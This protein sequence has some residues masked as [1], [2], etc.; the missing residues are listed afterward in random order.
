MTYRHGAAVAVVCLA[1]AAVMLPGCAAKKAPAG[2]PAMAYKLAEGKPVAYRNVQTATQTMEVMGQSMNIETR[3]TMIFTV[4][5]GEMK[6]AGQHLT[7]TI[8][9]IDAG[10]TMPQGDFTADTAPVLGKTFEMTLSATGKE[11]DITG[12][13]VIQYGVGPAGERS[14]KPDFQA[15]FPD[16]SASPVKIGDT[17]TNTDTV[18]VDEAGMKL[19]IASV[20]VSTFE[21]VE[22]LNGIECAR[23]RAAV[24]GTVKGEGEQQGAPVVIDSQTEGTDLWLFA[25]KLGTLAKYTS[26]LSMN[27][28]VTVGGAQGMAI[29]MKQQIRT[30]TVLIK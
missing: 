18:D 28:T 21:G 1:V 29:P 12:A 3:K 10:M 7:V 16:L 30:E 8:D 25:L 5:P 22:P 6:T 17:W 19:R 24:T 4:T 13:D 2:A 23:I 26:D 14:I 9:S 27:G 20:Y 15:I 11:L